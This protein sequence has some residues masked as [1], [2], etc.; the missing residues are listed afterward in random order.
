MSNEKQHSVLFTNRLSVGYSGS[1][2]DVV[3]ASD[4]SIE[5]KKSQLV[6]LIGI[7]GSGKS[8]LL[9]TIAGL[10][11]PLSGTIE[12]AGKS[13]T[14][15]TPDILA[16]SLSVV[17]TGQA[18]SK[19]LTVLELVALGRQPYTNWL[20]TLTDNDKSIIKYALEA[21]ETLEFKDRKCYE[22]SDGQLQ[23][24][25]IARALAQD[26]QL[27]LLDEPM[28]HLDLHHK[29]SI[30]Q[31]L[32]SI[33]H[34]QGKTVLFST[35]DIEYA[36]QLCDKVVVM[37]EG[38]ARFDTPQQLIEDGVIDGLFPSKTVLFDRESIRFS[39]DK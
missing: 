11:E 18:I 25:L 20:G 9:R 27:I 13:I 12:I 30:L 8:T 31:L 23:R 2:S 34:E 36:L 24:V 17:L 32:K 21:T 39:I 28:T 35:H 10:Q 3:V 15:Y 26:T 19:N 16:Q 7:N 38:L 14:N 5:L 4:I 22:L 37:Q 6:G 1:S 29:A 33:A